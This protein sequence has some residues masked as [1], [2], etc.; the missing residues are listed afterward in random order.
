MRVIIIGAGIAGL[1]AA[2]RLIQLGIE[3]VIL[4]GRNRSGGRVC[5]ADEFDIPIDLGASWIH[6][7]VG[8]PL[9][10]VAERLNVKL[11]VTDNPSLTSSGYFEIYDEDGHLVDPETETKMRDKFEELTKVGRQFMDALGKDLPL[12]SVLQLEDDDKLSKKE[13]RFFN[14]LKSGIE[15]WENTNLS[16]LSARGHYWENENQFSRPFP[17]QWFR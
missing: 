9:A 8:N 12:E 17:W 10:A 7:V 15:G 13:R 14:W 16:N 11:D 2:L 3:V 1:S 4:E 6:G 5:K